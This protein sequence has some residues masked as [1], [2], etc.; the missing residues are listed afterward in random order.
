MALPKLTQPEY[1]L[2]LPSTKEDIVVRPFLVKEEKILLMAMESE[3]AGDMLRAIKNIVEA[4]L[5]SDIKMNKVATF[6]LEYIFLKLRALSISNISKLQYRDKDD[7]EI[8]TIEVNLDN[9]ECTY[10]EEKAPDIIKIQDGV[11]MKLHYPTADIA[12]KMDGMSDE[13]D[14]LF[15][16]VA[17]SIEYITNG[18]DLIPIEE[19]SKAEINEFLESLPLKVFEDIRAF[20][21]GA[22]K[23]EHKVSYTNSKEKTVEITLRTLRDFF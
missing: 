23:L 2:T 11:T 18:D 20:Y 1:T 5:V 9:V 17:N 13:T 10:P 7:G 21:D 8:Y 15:F 3:D 4:C 22:P 19:V 14:M 16:F 6:D 12:D